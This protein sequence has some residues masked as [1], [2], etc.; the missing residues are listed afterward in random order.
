MLFTFLLYLFLATIV[1]YSWWQFGNWRQWQNIQERQSALS[2]EQPYISVLVP[3]RNEAENLPALLAALRAQTYP[4]FGVI[5]IDDH[6]SDS[7]PAILGAAAGAEQGLSMSLLSLA[8]LP[9]VETLVAHKKAAL[10]LGIEQSEAEIIFTTDADC[11]LPPDLLARVAAAFTPTVEVVLG[12]VFN[13]PVVGFCQYF[14]ALDLAA[15]QFLT[16]ISLNN[17]TPTLAN[18]ACLAFRKGSFN[19]VG[20]YVGVEHLPSGDDVLLLHKFR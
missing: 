9:G 16:A 19:R 15:Y 13:A 4:S 1:A 20:G 6:S 5:F 2:F 12:P 11:Y 3:F 18:G 17:G 14:Q 10:A 8:E 7:G